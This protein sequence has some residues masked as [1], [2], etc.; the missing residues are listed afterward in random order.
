MILLFGALADK[1]YRRMLQKI[2]P[3]AQTIIL[4]Q[5]QTKRAVPV[6]D[7]HTMLRQI[8]YPA[9]VTQNVTQAI[10]R[11]LTLAGKKD[12]ICA[13]G[14]LYLAGQVKQVF[15]EQAYCDKKA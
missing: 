13:A 3:L 2:A 7:I 1:D 12:L 11:A 8:G 5:L 14:S 10:E 6:N 15:S 9:I 4:T